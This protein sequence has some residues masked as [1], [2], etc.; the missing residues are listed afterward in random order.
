MKAIGNL[1]LVFIL[2]ASLWAQPFE[3]PHGGSSEPKSHLR[4]RISVIKI[5][6]LV[7]VLGLT[8]EQST[9]FFPAMNKHDADLERLRN[10]E[11][12]LL[13]TLEAQLRSGVANDATLEAR[14]DSVVAIRKQ[15]SSVDNEFFQKIGDILNTEQQAKLLLFGR[16]FDKEMRNVI[17]MGV[18]GD[19]QRFMPDAGKTR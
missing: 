11:D 12:R 10:D 17:D 18:R 16:T 4:E 15:R 9:V 13:D 8:E 1:A 7:T 14:I 2:A 6:K 3:R 19:K 5:W